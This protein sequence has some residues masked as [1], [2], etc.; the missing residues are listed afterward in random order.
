M[1]APGAMAWPEPHPGRHELEQAARWADHLLCLICGC[2][3]RTEAHA[4][5]A[6]SPRICSP[7]TRRI[8][9]CGVRRSL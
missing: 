8:S 2:R 5:C 6:G 3:T 1:E 7:G 9:D 4:C